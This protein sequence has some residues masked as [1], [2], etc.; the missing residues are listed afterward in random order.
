MTKRV[1][2]KEAGEGSQVVAK[3]MADRRR[4]LLHEQHAYGGLIR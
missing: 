1:M 2:W 4:R 3:Q